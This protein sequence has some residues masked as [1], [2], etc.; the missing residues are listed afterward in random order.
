MSEYRANISWRRQ[1]NDFAYNTY[2]RNHTISFAGG[3]EITASAAPEFKGNASLVNPEE[4]L[5]AA[6]SSCHMLTFLAIAARQRIIVDSYK[7][8]AVGV[9]TKNAQGKHF[10]S[11]VVLHPKIAFANPPALEVVQ[12]M[13]HQA[14]AECF[15]ANSVITHVSIET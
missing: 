15:I 10:I 3:S 14:H 13:H 1:T 9:M 8:D 7:D 11:Q 6:L 4:L 12:H 2:N 5:V